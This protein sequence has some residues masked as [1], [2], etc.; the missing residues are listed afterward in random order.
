MVCNNCWW[1]IPAEEWWLW[2]SDSALTH[3]LPGYQYPSMAWAT[4]IASQRHS[5]V[6]SS[7]PEFF[8]FLPSICLCFQGSSNGNLTWKGS[9]LPHAKLL[10]NSHIVTPLYS[11]GVGSLSQEAPSHLVGFE[12]W[13]WKVNK[14]RLVRSTHGMPK[15][16][17]PI[18]SHGSW[19]M[20]LTVMVVP[21]QTI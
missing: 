3:L 5:W 18:K 6:I 16:N 10:M 9:D 2:A 12:S 13:I 7:V 20:R 1:F 17:C 19:L 21:F 11:V 15:P 4:H 14:I 8:F